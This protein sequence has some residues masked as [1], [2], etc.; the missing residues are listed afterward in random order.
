M[1]NRSS[2]AVTAMCLTLF[3]AAKS[4]WTSQYAALPAGL[5]TKQLYIVPIDANTCWGTLF[6]VSSS[7]A[8]YIRT[9]NG[10][11]TW[12][13]STIPGLSGIAASSMSA[14]D[15]QTAW[16]AFAEGSTSSGVYRTTN[17]GTSWTKQTTAF[18]SGSN[19]RFVKFFDTTSGLAVGNPNGGFWEI[20]TT[21]DGGNNWTRVASD[22][23][24][25]PLSGEAAYLA[26]APCSYGGRWFWFPTNR[27]S[28][29]RTTNRGRSWTVS[30]N[31]YPG[32]IGMGVAFRDSLNGLLSGDG[33]TVGF[34]K[35]T[36]GGVTW[37]QVS[38]PSGVT[39]SFVTAVPGTRSY[40]AS[41]FD[42]FGW[43]PGSAYTRD[44]GA[45]W[46]AIDNRNHGRAAFLSSSIGWS[47]GGN[48][49]L[50]RWTGSTLVDLWN[51]QYA[52]FNTKQLYF[53][54]VDTNNCWAAPVNDAPNQGRFIRTT[55]GGGTWTSSIVPGTTGVV[56][57]SITAANAQTAWI[58]FSDGSVGV[59]KT[60][61]SGATWTRQASAFPSGGSPRFIK[62]FDLQNGLVVGNPNGG[63]WEIYTTTDGGTNW[64][65]V[66]ST[67]IPAPLSGETAYIGGSPC[68]YG[69]RWF[70]FTT[71]QQSV[72]KTTNRGQS[73]TVSRNAYLGAVGMGV[74]FRDSLN[75]LLSGDPSTPGPG[76]R[77]STDGGATWTQVA[78]PPGVTASFITAVPGTRGTYVASSFDLYGWS[79]GSAYTRDDGATWTTIDNRNHGR[80]VFLNP[81]IGWSGGGNDS[82]YAWDRTG[83]GSALLPVREDRLT[84]PSDFVLQQNYPNPFNP[85]TRIPFSVRGSGFV[86]LRVFDVLGREVRTLVDENLQAGRYEAT[87][88]AAGLASGTYF[89]RLQAGE[90]VQTKKLLLL[91]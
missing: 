26:G 33:S 38:A 72:Y 71:S 2:I 55:N 43:T 37:A 64:T 51:P 74:A 31:A 88:D 48:D 52:G 36:D 46:T 58:L 5:D 7:Q 14:V 54:A 49:S 81:A 41:S 53:A 17:G 66:A 60:T 75:G 22:S 3:S 76:F 47:G 24:P 86:S 63:Y 6:S 44:D 35:S 87:F 57:S 61:N 34:R 30:R 8:S 15:G 16:I 85:A 77:K 10:G 79:P 91:R 84:T 32:A 19:P 90:F 40:V 80:C 4:Q 73:W 62:F 67:N 42:L 13:A 50:Y 39:A 29:Y 1:H 65:R 23:I 20:Y 83:T 89:Y 28:V 82:L 11:T 25:L 68:S 21:T 18:P 69:D 70:W 9:V 27:Q 45:T 78:S 56:A 59:Q 12:T